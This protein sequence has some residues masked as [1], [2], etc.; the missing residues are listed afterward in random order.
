M[1]I[2]VMHYLMAVL[3]LLILQCTLSEQAESSNIIWT[4]VNIPAD[5]WPGIKSLLGKDPCAD[6]MKYCKDLATLIKGRINADA[7][8]KDCEPDGNLTMPNDPDGRTVCWIRRKQ[9][10]LKYSPWKYEVVTTTRFEARFWTENATVSHL[11]YAEHP[12]EKF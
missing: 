7:L 5:E 1:F 6:D 4:N 2:R 12:K 9:T 8:R 10:Y 11:R 3:Y